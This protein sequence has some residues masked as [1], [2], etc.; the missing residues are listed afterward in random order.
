MQLTDQPL[1]GLSPDVIYQFHL[2]Y[3]LGR[4]PNIQFFHSV[5]HSVIPLEE[6]MERYRIYFDIFGYNQP[7]HRDIIY[8]YLSKNSEN[9]MCTDDITYH[10]AVMN[11]KTEQP[12]K[13]KEGKFY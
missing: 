10:T 11:W 9:G 1:K 2:L 12:R 4:Y 7:K 6:A 13:T 5:S 8:T 3:A